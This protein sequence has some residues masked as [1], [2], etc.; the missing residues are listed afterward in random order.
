[1]SREEANKM[2]EEMRRFLFENEQSGLKCEIPR[3][4]WTFYTWREW[5]E[6]LGYREGGY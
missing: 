1:M 4:D 6:F 2:N 5:F 3:K